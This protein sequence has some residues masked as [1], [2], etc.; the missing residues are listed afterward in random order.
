MIY[1]DAAIHD[2]GRMVM[3]HLTADGL[4]ELHAAAQGIGVARRWFQN[5]PGS[6]PHYDVCKSKRAL[7]IKRGA[8]EVDRK[9]MCRIIRY[10]RDMQYGPPKP[11]NCRQPHTNTTPDL[12]G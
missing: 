3:C 11:E 12:F 9:E 8:V 4:D 7:A 10:W 2:F 1:V 6:T 5:H